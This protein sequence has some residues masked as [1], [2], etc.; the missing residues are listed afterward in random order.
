M[1]R[2]ERPKYQENLE[3]LD[4]S[5]DARGNDHHIKI[6]ASKLK[7]VQDQNAVL[8]RENS[9]LFARCHGDNWRFGR[10]FGSEVL[11][12]LEEIEKILALKS[13]QGKC[14]SKPRLSLIIRSFRKIVGIVKR[15]TRRKEYSALC[16]SGLFSRKYYLSNNLDVATSGQD[17]VLHFLFHGAK[18]YRN[19]SQYFD[20]KYYLET[21]PDV[22]ATGM[23]PLAHYILSGE[24]EGRRP[25]PFFDPNYYSKQIAVTEMGAVGP[26]EHYISVGWIQGLNP[27]SEFDVGFYLRKNIDVRANALEP[28]A[29]FL[30]DG[31]KEGRLASP[32]YQEWLRHFCKVDAQDL[33]SIRRHI[34]LF[35][36]KPSFAIALY[37]EPGLLQDVSSF[38]SALREQVYP[39]SEVWLGCASASTSNLE[40]T[41]K[42]NDFGAVD[43]HLVGATPGEFFEQFR[44]GTSADYMLFSKAIPVLSPQSLY[45]F[46][47]IVQRNSHAVVLYCDED[48]INERGERE[49][50]F[51][52]PEFDNDLLLTKDYLG[53]LCAINSD[54]VRR[55]STPEYAAWAALLR[56]LTLQIVEEIDPVSIFHLAEVLV[57]LPR[58][59]GS[60]STSD[61]AS[62][63]SKVLA[64]S[65]GSATAR[66]VDDDRIRII[67]EINGDPPLVSII[68]PTKDKSQLLA[69]CL[70]GIRHGTEY[71]KIEVILVD[72]NSSEKE[73]VALLA[74]VAEEPNFKIVPFCQDFNF[75]SMINVGVEASRGEIVVLLNNDIEIIDRYWLKELVVEAVREEIGCVG[76]KLLYPDG[77]IQH[78][79]IVLGHTGLATLA[80]R[81]ILDGSDSYMNFADT[82]RQVSA[83]TAACLAIR[84]EVFDRAG[85]F[86]EALPVAFNDVDFCLRV[87]GCGLK[88]LYTPLVRL[89][90][91]E[92][93]SRGADHE[94]LEKTW[95]CAKEEARVKACWSDR[96]FRDPNY[97]PNLALDT[98][99]FSLAYPPRTSK[100]WR[101]AQSSSNFRALNRIEQLNVYYGDSNY[102]RV[103]DSM[104]PFSVEKLEQRLPGVS[105]VILTKDKPEYIIPLIEGLSKQRRSF[106]AEGLPFEILVGDTGSTDSKVLQFY[107]DK[108]EL[109]RLFPGLSYH[110]SRC[111]NLLVKQAAYDTVLFLN[112]DIII[113]SDSQAIVFLRRLLWSDNKIGCVG[114]ALWFPDGA[115]QH[116]GI[117]FIA[118]SALWGMPRHVCHRELVGRDS[119]SERA[120]YPAVT[121]AFLM[122]RR[123]LFD[124]LGGFDERYRRECQDVAY[125]LDLHRLGYQS[126]C[127]NFDHIIHI[128]NAT[129]LKGEE[130]LEDRKRFLRL[131]GA[132]IEAAF[133]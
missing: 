105:V 108:K 71:S 90:H 118:E 127:A 101:V 96:I 50:P 74:S 1:R 115:V 45:C 25:N 98:E 6:L 110:F 16:N 116:M 23:N 38:A 130:D 111:N 78:A 49:A 22:K 4:V 86:D 9:S 126:V 85:G 122:T 63:V 70:E 92:S 33:S 77:T 58:G 69:S 32:S 106:E 107:R 99:P 84:R 18:E 93:V 51:F 37:V 95:R 2:E 113:P 104:R 29:H 97:N 44:D 133:L 64:V 40:D 65:D 88:N 66:V 83:V 76:A 129:R 94:S 87:E 131:Y 75:S 7:M 132:Y 80:F 24:D 12:R 11:A 60:L 119:V 48:I 3:A 124:K 14:S 53:N 109:F 47:D 30:K 125:C 5:S 100:P 10:E 102:A 31:R 57:S 55:A 42:L 103:L 68:I 46:A 72:N 52:K 91:H 112:N 8:R 123:R 21:Y 73:A 34:E 89:V 128:E 61:D 19:P 26:L 117:E 121:G 62:I 54:H 82:V 67:R 13:P 27:S 56:G 81:G 114:A 120:I 36:F 41:I 79:G 35:Y 15:F 39:F 20:V 43:L 59:R 17:E 28:L